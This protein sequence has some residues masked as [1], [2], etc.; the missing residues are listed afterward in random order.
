M[1]HER[2]ANV[3]VL[4]ATAWLSFMFFALT[5]TFLS[6][7]L[8]SIGEE[9]TVNYRLQGALAPVRSLSLAVMAFVCGYVAD[10]I[11]KKW[12]MAG[13]MFV[14]AGGV[15]WV[16]HCRDYTALIVAM[17]VMGAGLGGIEGL[18]SP[19]VA[20]L[21]PRS[22]ATHMN[23]LHAFYPT[24][25]AL[26]AV[27]AGLALRLGA[28]WR[29]LFG[30]AV[31]PICAIGL[32]Y[33]LCRFPEESVVERRKPLTVR[34][35]LS[36]PTFWLLSFIMALTA[37]CEGSLTYWGPSFLQAEYG[38]SA[39]LG[40][41]GLAVFG[42]T[43]AIGRFGMGGLVRVLPMERV[44]LGMAVTGGLGTLV[45]VLVQHVWLSVVLMAMSGLFCAAFWPCILSLATE[46]IA[47]G[48]STL[49]AMLSVAGIIGFGGVPSLVGQVAETCPAGLRAGMALI[50][51]GFA[52]S[53]LFLIPVFRASK[54]IPGRRGY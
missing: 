48:S 7:S 46:K 29:G 8:R 43:M 33:L 5:S 38:S 32:V 21:H 42:V 34:S 36:S 27:V 53:G 15:Y 39:L 41:V 50:P 23:V 16:A 26:S 25:L 22:V 17:L 9:F 14:I 19:L 4:T 54:R 47:A 28:T 13:A 37:G 2:R 35:I 24:G 10:R 44:M 51:M 52:L 18:I 30:A 1:G 45:L 20:E 6:V 11:G 12:L 49:L 31:L 3:R 40:G